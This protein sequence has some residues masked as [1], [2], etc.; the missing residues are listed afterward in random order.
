MVLDE[1]AGSIL[2]TLLAFSIA[3]SL[4]KSRNH[5]E[6]STRTENPPCPGNAELLTLIVAVCNQ[7]R[8]ID[9]NVQSAPSNR[10]ISVLRPLLSR[11]SSSSELRKSLPLHVHTLLSDFLSCLRLSWNTTNDKVSA[12]CQAASSLVDHSNPCLSF[13]THCLLADARLA[14]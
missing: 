12:I 5:L 7:H 13:H 1:S 2:S 3:T 9:T 11:I 6:T 14:R 10:L 4:A 8:H